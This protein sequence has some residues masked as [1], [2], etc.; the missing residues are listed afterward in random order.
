MVFD[1][2]ELRVVK[3]DAQGA[4]KLF[5]DAGQAVAVR[6][7]R[8]GSG[9]RFG[10]S[11]DAKKF[12]HQIGARSRE[13]A[14]WPRSAG[15]V[16]ARQRAAEA[17]GSPAQCLTRLRRSSS[18]AK[19]RTPSCKSAAEASPWKALRP[20]MSFLFSLLR[21]GIRCANCIRTRSGNRPHKKQREC[22]QGDRVTAKCDES[23]A[24][25]AG[26]S[27]IPGVGCLRITP[28]MV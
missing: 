25:W 23:K 2:V 13:M 14:M 10:V 6:G 20:R 21:S 11:C 27:A 22:R 17:E 1:E 8:F 18:M 7:A 4:A 24:H 28:A 15:F 9:P 16:P 12:A 26:L 19:V 5:L 3:I